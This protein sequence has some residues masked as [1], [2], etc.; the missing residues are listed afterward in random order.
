M[1]ENL[2]SFLVIKYKKNT[3]TNI[4]LSKTLAIYCALQLSYICAVMTVQIVA[5]CKIGRE[6]RKPLAANCTLPFFFL[7][8]R[9]YDGWYRKSPPPP[10]HHPSYNHHHH[11]IML[12]SIFLRTNKS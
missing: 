7:S 11:L 1:A 9:R 6:E 5:S 3:P 12:Y 4:K 10:T 8:C 2:L